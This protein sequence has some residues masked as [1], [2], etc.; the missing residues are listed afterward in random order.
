VSHFSYKDKHI[1]A[2]IDIRAASTADAFNREKIMF[3]QLQSDPTLARAQQMVGTLLAAATVEKLNV[4]GKD[5]KLT[6]ETLLDLPSAFTTL[7]E[8][9]VYE[10]NPQWQFGLSADQLDEIQKKALQPTSGS[11]DSIEQPAKAK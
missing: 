7:W 5:I 2:E 10:E 11:G 6:A 9:R 4:D 1:H 8:M 3:G